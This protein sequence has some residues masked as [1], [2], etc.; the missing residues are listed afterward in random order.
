VVVN[1]N[2]ACFVNARQLLVL[3]ECREHSTTSSRVSHHCM[4]R[5]HRRVRGVTWRSSTGVTTDG[6]ETWWT[7]TPAHRRVNCQGRGSRADI[8]V[9]GLGRQ[10]NPRDHPG[11]EDSLPS[12]Y[13][14]VP[15]TRKLPDC[16][17]DRCCSCSRNIIYRRD[18]LESRKGEDLLHADDISWCYCIS[19]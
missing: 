12:K 8:A 16:C 1:K 18:R 14:N 5:G 3:Q 9:A 10:S 13:W 6:E 7:P 2:V 4:I 11:I 15:P 17:E 19:P